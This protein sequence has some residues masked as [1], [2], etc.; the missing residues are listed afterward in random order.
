VDPRFRP[1]DLAPGDAGITSGS[2]SRISVRSVRSREDPDFTD[3]FARLWAEFGVRG[4]MEHPEVIAGRLAWDPAAPLRNAALLYELLVL[5]Q[6]DEIVAVRDHTAVVRLDEHGRARAEPTVVHLSHALVEPAHRGSGLAGWLRALP[7]DAARRCAE[8]AGRVGAPIILVAE[9]E[10]PDPSDAAGMTRLRSY[11]RAGFRK[12]DPAA[13]PYNQPD[14]RPPALLEGQTPVS[15][16]LALIVR[17]VGAEGEDTMPAA[18]VAA[19]VQSIYAVYAVHLAPQAVEPLRAAAAA[20]T[21]RDEPF[22]LVAP[23]A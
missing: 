1:A 6:A 5:R 20:W 18:E 22:R 16:P 11:E 13:A 10:H 12:I 23:T 7:L 19:V 14:F 4:E 21:A 3:V 9:M 8:A 15:L 2:W 17:R